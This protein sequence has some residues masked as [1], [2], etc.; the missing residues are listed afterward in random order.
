MTSFIALHALLLVAAVAAEPHRIPLRKV[1]RAAPAYH[2]SQGPFSIT[3]LDSSPVI[4]K[5][6]EDAQYFIEISIGNPPQSFKVVP[7]TGS[8]NLWVPSKKCKFTQVSCDLHNKYDSKKSS[9]YV[10]DGTEFKIQYGSGAAE[11][12]MSKDTVSVGG[13]TVTNQ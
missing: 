9:T 11:G 12:F 7:D 1:A 13:I 6:F 5:N 3:E 8:S 4:V 2:T 10:A